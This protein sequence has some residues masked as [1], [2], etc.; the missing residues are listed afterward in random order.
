MTEEQ[1][2]EQA[3]NC[4]LIDKRTDENERMSIMKFAKLI[5]NTVIQEA[6]EKALVDVETQNGYKRYT[7]DKNSILKLKI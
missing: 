7:V 4:D 3:W 2:I 5:H 1:I 6:A